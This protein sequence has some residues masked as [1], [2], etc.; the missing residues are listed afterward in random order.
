VSFSPHPDFATSTVRL[1]AY[2]I[3]EILLGNDSRFPWL[4]LVP[5]VESAREIEDLPPDARNGLMEECVRAGA[6]VRAIGEALGR[7]VEKLNIAAL[8]NVTPQLHVHVIGRRSDD[9]AWPRPVWGVGEAVPWSAE[10]LATIRKV[11]FEAD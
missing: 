5:R 2:G 10:D 11:F 6:L 1:G 3:S 7:P 4:I 8:G 9:P